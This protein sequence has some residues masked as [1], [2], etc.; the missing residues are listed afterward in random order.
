MSDIGFDG[1]GAFFVYLALLVLLG[2]ILLTSFIALLRTRTPWTKHRS[3]GYFAG[4][5]LGTFVTL[6]LL[7]F[8]ETGDLGIKETMDTWSLGIALIVLAIPLTWGFRHRRKVK[9]KISV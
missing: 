1:L 7:Y 5:L 3:F 8:T 2:I 6:L 9:K 4:S